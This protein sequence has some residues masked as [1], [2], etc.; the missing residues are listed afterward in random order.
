MDGLEKLT[1]FIEAA[2]RHADLPDHP[3][4]M[5]VD[6]IQGETGVIGVELESGAE[7]FIEVKP[8]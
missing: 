7:F 5:S 8:A 4:L 3:G 6:R 2:L 1:A